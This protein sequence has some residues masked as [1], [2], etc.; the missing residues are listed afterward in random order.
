MC[1]LKADPGARHQ[2]DVRR[3]SAGVALIAVLW[4]SSLLAILAAGALSSSRTDLR[5]AANAAELAKARA[6]ADAG[7]HQ[8]LYAMLTRPEGQT[9]QD[10]ALR[11][12]LSLEEGEVRYLVRDEDGK[13]DV[14]AAS[15]ELLAGLFRAI[16]LSGEQ[17]DILAD[18]LQDFRDEDSDPEPFGAEDDDY[19]AAGRNRGSLDRPLLAI[20]DLTEVIGMTDDVYQRI[21][22]FVTIYA[23]ADGFD[24]S[25]AAAATLLALPA[26]TPDLARTMATQPIDGD[27]LEGL[28]EDVAL[29]IEPYLIPSRELVYSIHSLGS[30]EGGG[31]FL[32]ETIIALDGGVRTLPFTVYTWSRG[33]LPDEGSGTVHDP[34]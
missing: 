11:F 34:R 24:P 20:S 33:R 2:E 8:A 31:R 32:R 4:I 18:R 26:M 10:G 21:K 17:A 12:A 29:E 7:V 27:P 30:S 6:L 22:P 3:R 13:I 23:D 14:N 19:L 28:P 5:L 15:K 9:W 1:G 25:R 16:G